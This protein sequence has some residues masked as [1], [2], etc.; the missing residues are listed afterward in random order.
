MKKLICF[1]FLVGLVIAWS[2]PVFSHDVD[3]GQPAT[4]LVCVLNIDMSAGQ[5][6]PM[7][8]PAPVFVGADVGYAV[9]GRISICP[10][11]GGS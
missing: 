2:P 8:N 10:G 5:V 6:T 4:E 3:I 1:L 9:F 11:S 7:L